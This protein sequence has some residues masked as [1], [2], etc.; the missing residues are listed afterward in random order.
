[1]VVLEMVH[2]VSA[3]SFHLLIARH[4]AEHNLGETFTEKRVLLNCFLLLNNVATNFVHIKTD[5]EEAVQIGFL[6]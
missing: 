4:S 3:V 5:H 1:M 6:M 2:E